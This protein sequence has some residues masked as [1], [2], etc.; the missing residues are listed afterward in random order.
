MSSCKCQKCSNST[1]QLESSGWEQKHLNTTR[2]EEQEEIPWRDSLSVYSQ[3]DSQ[4][5]GFRAQPCLAVLQPHQVLFQGLNFT[6]VA[7]KKE[8]DI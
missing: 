8:G 7:R 3:T 2:G 4:A 5:L 6:F 1:K